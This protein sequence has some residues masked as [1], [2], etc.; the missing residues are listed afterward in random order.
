MS[1]SR[2]T[3]IWC[4]LLDSLLHSFR[5]NKYL[6]IPVSII[7]KVL[8]FIRNLPNNVKKRYLETPTKTSNQGLGKAAYWNTARI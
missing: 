2:D 6:S 3:N 7:F 8:N 1:M 5:C 4:V